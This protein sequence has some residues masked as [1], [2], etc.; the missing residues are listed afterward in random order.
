M[1][2]ETA[3]SGH[4]AALNVAGETRGGASAEESL[5]HPTTGILHTL[6]RHDTDNLLCSL[7]GEADVREDSVGV[8]QPACGVEGTSEGLASSNRVTIETRATHAKTLD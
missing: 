2:A 8:I 5:V 4:T 1:T 7:V 6:V 3:Q